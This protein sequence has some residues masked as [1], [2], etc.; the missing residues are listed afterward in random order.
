MENVDVISH[1]VL[2][3]L[4]NAQRSKNEK[5]LSEADKKNSGIQQ[6]S[7]KML[8]DV[9]KCLIYTSSRYLLTFL[10][11]V[12]ALIGASYLHG[13]FDLAVECCELFDLGVKWEPIPRRVV[14]ILSR[15]ESTDDFPTS[16]TDAERMLKYTFRRKLLLVE[17]LTHSSYHFDDRTVSYERMEFL[18][19]AGMSKRS[20]GG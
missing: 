11:L 4:P 3:N 9:G 15:V 7:T 16:I 19:D 2:Q 18:G 12:E 14:A 10:A 1:D 8:A 17:A 5:G 20:L 6:L 13:G